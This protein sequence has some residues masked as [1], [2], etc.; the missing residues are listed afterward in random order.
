MDM[1]ILVSEKKRRQYS[2]IEYVFW[3]KL[4]RHSLLDTFFIRFN[5]GNTQAGRKHTPREGDANTAEQ[6]G[7]L[8]F[9]ELL[10]APEYGGLQRPTAAQETSCRSSG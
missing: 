7:H 9:G 2:G 8:Y 10:G 1:A 3:H 5:T 6:L 4:L